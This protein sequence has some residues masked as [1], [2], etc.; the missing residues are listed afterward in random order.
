MPPDDLY[1]DF[2]PF[3][4]LYVGDWLADLPP[5]LGHS[6]RA[7]GRVRAH[8]SPQ[9]PPGGRLL[10]D[11]FIPWQRL[12]ACPTEPV[13]RVDRRN[14]D[15][16]DHIRG[17]NRYELDPEVNLEIRRQIFEVTRPDGAI[18]RYE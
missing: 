1:R 12:A 8:L 9:P 6:H 11:V 7:R 15:S 18:Q 3:Y 5:Y 14:P 2:S 13:L 4:D 17:W 10:I 16:G